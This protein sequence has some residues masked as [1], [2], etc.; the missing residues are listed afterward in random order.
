MGLAANI[1]WVSL[2]MFELHLMSSSGEVFLVPPVFM[3]IFLLL[4][5]T[6]PGILNTMP[7]LYI[8]YSNQPNKF[9]HSGSNQAF[10]DFVF[11]NNR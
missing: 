11:H 8:Y 10:E 2:A 7:F 9:L 5:L 6:P 3:C 1:N 4:F